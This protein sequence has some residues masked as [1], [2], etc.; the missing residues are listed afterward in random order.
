MKLL[1]LILLSPIFLFAQPRPVPGGS[2]AANQLLNSLP[3]DQRN[4]VQLP[5][6]NMNRYEWHYL[7]QVMVGRTGLAL[8][9]MTAQ[10]K[11]LVYRLMQTYLSEE[12]FIRARNIMDFEFF[13]KE[14]Q[15]NNYLRVPENYSIAIYGTPAADSIWGWKISGHHL[16]LN[17]TIVKDQMAFAPFFFGVFPATV[18][19]GPKKGTR[20]LKDQEDLGF[21]LLHA[22][23]AD[24]QRKAIFL[25]E[26]YSDILTTNALQVG[27]F[28]QD[29]ILAKD[30]NPDQK[31]ILNKLIMS[32]LNAMPPLLA[33]YRMKKIAAEDYNAIRFAWAGSGKPGEA[34]YYRI[35]GKSFLVEFDNTQNNANHIHSVWRD[36]N[37]D[38]GED[39][40]REHYRTAAH[41]QH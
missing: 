19:D 13:L 27:T 26:A 25:Q 10:Q 35:Q 18:A 31:T 39:L 30:L 34:H 1:A 9:D 6:S 7:P 16:A 33:Q 5:F 21:E 23:N 3:A 32:Y 11:E 40:L 14:L 12:G 4:I 36:F 2:D 22:L 29:G 41:H 15:P 24:Q 38:F 8:K 17:F 20:L 37:G 28:Q